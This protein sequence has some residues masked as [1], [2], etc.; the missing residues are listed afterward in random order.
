MQ[1]YPKIILYGANGYS[2]KLILGEL[3]KRGIEP[4]I[5]GR[6][7]YA[8]NTVANKYNLTS[9]IFSLNDYPVVLDNLNEAHT[10]L[11]CAGP[12]SETAE[13]LMDACLETKTNYLDITGEIKIFEEAWKRNENSIKAGIT[14]LPGIGFDVV[15]TDCISKKLKEEMP[16]AVSLKLGIAAKKSKISRGTLIVSINQFGEN[17]IVR[18]KGKLVPIDRGSKTM[19]I[20]F[21]LFKSEAMAVQWGDVSN[22]FY[23]TGI[24]NIEVYLSLPSILIKLMKHSKYFKKFIGSDFTK[25]NLIRFVS[26]NITG[27]NEKQRS[28]AGLFIRGEVENIKGEKLEQV[29]EFPDGYALT[30]KSAVEIVTRVLKN[31]VKPGTQTPSLA[32]GSSFMDQFVV[33]RIK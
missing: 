3:L 26:R 5:A 15:A 18:E 32:F 14:I 25:Q 30:S 31:D 7:S 17:S 23:S 33:R 1:N 11:N 9:H 6:N 13:I 2:A 22:A 16:D 28:K 8:I 20:D 21:G 29:Y 19:T 24:P 4:V 12:F 10:L 27:P